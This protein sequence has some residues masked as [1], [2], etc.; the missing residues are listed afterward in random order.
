MALS[1]KSRKLFLEDSLSLARKALAALRA[2]DQKAD[3]QQVRKLFHAI[4]S[5]KGT[6]AMVP[7][8]VDVVAPLQKIEAVLTLGGDFEGLARRHL[9]WR[10]AALGALE[11]ALKA[12]KQLNSSALAQSSALPVAQ[13]SRSGELTDEEWVWV[14]LEISDTSVRKTHVRLEDII[15]FRP[16]PGLSIASSGVAPCESWN[17]QW[18]RRYGLGSSASSGVAGGLSLLLHLA[19]EHG[20][21]DGSVCLLALGEKSRAGG[22]VPLRE[23]LAQGSTLWRPEPGSEGDTSAE[24]AA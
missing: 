10:G 11:I 5:F 12:L 1:E 22:V 19:P 2:L 4:H 24:I 13:E 18:I 14:F 6:A 21:Q 16:R 23:A 8:A 20:E 9:Q 15:E 17:G 7:D 3:A